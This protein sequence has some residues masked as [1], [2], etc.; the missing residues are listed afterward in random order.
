[1]AF[2]AP[3]LIDRHEVSVQQ[4]NQACLAR[5]DLGQADTRDVRHQGL[6][7]CGHLLR[8]ALGGTE[9]PLLALGK[10]YELYASTRQTSLPSKAQW[11]RA[12]RGARGHLD[13][14]SE[15]VNKVVAENGWEGA[16]VGKTYRYLTEALWR[17]DK[18]FDGEAGRRANPNGISQMI[19][20]VYEVA[21]DRA[22]PTTY[23]VLGASCSE[24][25][26]DDRFG[27]FLAV[28]EGRQATAW[29][30]AGLRC[31]RTVTFR[32]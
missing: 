27:H 16:N 26:D 31:V 22:L 19:G 25:T 11:Y 6:P 7:I 14:W 15:Y 24:A 12:L 4:W 18:T 32:D 5:H 3:F 23:C 17:V 30:R 28:G 2:V 8:G 13:W 9:A 10:Q 1:M 29:E 20:N 21:R